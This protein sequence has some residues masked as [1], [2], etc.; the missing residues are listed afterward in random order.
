[1][2]NTKEIVPAFGED[3]RKEFML[4]EKSVFLNHGSFGSMPRCVHDR[5][6]RYL[7]E[8]E[9]H[10]DNWF[11]YNMYKYLAVSK[12]KVAE[13]MGIH[14]ENTFFLQNV[15][16][17]IN[18]VLKTYPLR[19]GDAYLITSLTYHAVTVTTRATVARKEGAVVYEMNIKFP[20]TSDDS[21][22]E[23]YEDFLSKHPDVKLSVVDHI[24][25]PTSL[26][27]PVKRIVEV[28]HRH[29]VVVVVDAAHI[30]GQLKVD[31]QDIDADFY[32]GNLHKWVCCP[33]SCAFIWTNPKRHHSWF[34]PLVT[35]SFDK[36]LHDAF[37]YEGTK[38]DTPYICSADG[39]DYYNRIG[40]LKTVVEYGSTLITNGITYLEQKWGTKRLAIPEHM[41]APLLRVLQ[42]PFIP[43]F[44]DTLEEEPTGVFKGKNLELQKLILDRFVRR[45][46]CSYYYPRRIDGKTVCF[47]L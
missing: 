44:S 35:S 27:L 12:A 17:A 25:S 41:E 34:K 39:I 43:G 29:D 11:R 31:I 3:I 6:I 5:Q 26:V 36:N 32:T 18:T 15:T 40:G 21:I 4:R 42:L 47:C 23:M 33:R 2:T 37:A 46:D 13:F 8:L 16:K 28:C 30:P 9:S 20:V 24:S 19:R 14:T 38:D 1:M 22:L 45:A 7:A 10:P